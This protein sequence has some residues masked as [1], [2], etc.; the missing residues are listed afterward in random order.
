MYP[1]VSHPVNKI[2]GHIRVP[3]DKSCSHRAVMLGGLAQG[4]SRFSGLLEGEDVLS[5]MASLR[6]LGAQI[7]KTPDGQ[8]SV[9]GIGLSPKADSVDVDFGNSGTSAR[10]LMGVFAGLGVR[11]RM[12]GDASLVKRPMNRVLTPLRAMGA[13]DDAAEHGRLPFSLWSDGPLKALDYEMPLASAQV[14]SCI[15]LAGLMA[16][17]ETCVT[18]FSPSRDH[19]EKMLRAFG[20]TVDIDRSQLGKRKI[21]IQGGQAL[22]ATSGQIPGDP[23]SAAF[24]V[25][26]AMIAQNGAVL[27]ENVLSNSTR[28]GFFDVVAHM[29]GDIGAEEGEV[30]S[31]GEGTITLEA[32][33]SALRGTQV[34][35]ALVPSMIDEFPMLAVL[36]AFAKGETIVTGAEDLR[37]K[38]SDR[39]TAII[40]M[41]RVN[42]VACE[43]RPD[44]FVVQGCDGPPPGGGLVETRHDHR[45]AMSALVMGSASQNPVR[46]D[47]G[48]AIATSF[49][50][51]FTD[52][53]A[54]G[55]DIRAS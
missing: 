36:A 32:R 6:A 47:D 19:T 22:S 42:G 40:D 15:L 35:E 38:E 33:H 27:V 50:S 37:H 16:Q 12:T 17:G 30:E 25:G 26:A 43:E 34:A 4:E 52:M 1:W 3:G 11:A 55:M 8:W 5:T 31:F 49:P 13:K 23:S 9:K 7:E 54:L 21:R 45:I 20:A 51:F 18:E 53:A 24:L 2:K 48:T 28:S 44:G 39:I 46:I 29:G 14:K 10:L 41:L